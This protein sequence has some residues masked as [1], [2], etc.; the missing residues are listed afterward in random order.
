MIVLI[1]WGI[2]Q[3]FLVGF[4]C[5]PA[6]MFIPGLAD[7]C[8]ESNIVWY[9]TSIVNIVTDFMIF[10]LPIPAIRSLQLRRKQKFLV[11]SVFSLGFL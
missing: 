11:G 1:V 4:A 9:L 3:E 2:A 8:I 10:T 7:I 5:V 6:S